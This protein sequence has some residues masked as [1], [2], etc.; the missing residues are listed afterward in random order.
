[1]QLNDRSAEHDT[2][3]ESY[4]N[5][6][7]N[8]FKKGNILHKLRCAAGVIQ[9]P[10]ITQLQI[11]TCI[12]EYD[13]L[14]YNNKKL[15]TFTVSSEFNL[16]Y[17]ADFKYK[18]KKNK[19]KTKQ[20]KTKNTHTHMQ[21]SLKVGFAQSFLAAQKISVAQFCFFF[22]WGGGGG[23][24]APCPSA[25]TCLKNCFF[26]FSNYNKCLVLGWW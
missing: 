21:T 24:A 26:L 22:F 1:M 13:P 20:N 6:D 12:S 7:Y 16:L 3:L 14:I 2:I 8:K 10:T 9:C 23:A 17:H 5:T 4:A 11:C 25:H 15:I 19:T 18:I